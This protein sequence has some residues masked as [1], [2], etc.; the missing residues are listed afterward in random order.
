MQNGNHQAHL[1]KLPDAVAVVPAGCVGG[2]FLR[3]FMKLEGTLLP[4]SIAGGVGKPGAIFSVL[5]VNTHMQR[6]ISV[7][8]I[9]D[10]EDLNEALVMLLESAGY[11]VKAYLNVTAYTQANDPLP[12]VYLIDGHL[13]RENGVDLC[14]RLI[15]EPATKNKPVVL[16][17]ANDDVKVVSAAAGAA[18]FLA[19]PFTKKQLITILQQVLNSPTGFFDVPS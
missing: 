1:G 3:Q 6:T 5:H 18:A 14:R 11:K 9:E 16:T 8:V 17:S 4:L 12:D 15:S 10:D 19:K 7:A 13:G 2:E